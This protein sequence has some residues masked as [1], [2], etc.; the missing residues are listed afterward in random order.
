[1]A[2]TGTVNVC[3]TGFSVARVRVAVR[4]FA[5]TFVHCSPGP[6]LHIV[7]QEVAWGH[8]LGVQTSSLSLA[9]ENCET[10][11]S[12]HNSPRRCKRRNTNLNFF[13]SKI[14]WS[15]RLADPQVPNS[16]CRPSTHNHIF[17][18]QLCTVGDVPSVPA[19]TA[20]PVVGK[21]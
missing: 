6:P 12:S 8:C 4:I 2:Q 21:Q 16:S 11:R 15:E 10:L 19:S 3:I 1:M 7:F 5:A 9:L 14:C 18:G 13:P 17:Y 20:L